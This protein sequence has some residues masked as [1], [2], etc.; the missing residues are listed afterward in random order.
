ML[1][2]KRVRT[3]V[4]L[5]TLCVAILSSGASFCDEQVESAP[6]VHKLFR[7]V[8]WK[9]ADRPDADYRPFSRKY[10]E[11]D[12]PALIG[13]MTHWAYQVRAELLWLEQFRRTGDRLVCQMT[14]EK[15][16]FP[17]D[18]V[19]DPLWTKEHIFELGVPYFFESQILDRKFRITLVLLKEPRNP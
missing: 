15:N 12:S 18:E 17:L 11:V 2:R 10:G 16:D 1:N 4:I 3:S 5:M 8:E 6:M 13:I 7:L 14:F 19:W 9:G